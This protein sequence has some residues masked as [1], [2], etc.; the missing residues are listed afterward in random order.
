LLHGVNLSKLRTAAQWRRA[1][2]SAIK[3]EFVLTLTKN[4]V[5]LLMVLA[6]GQVFNG[7][8]ASMAIGYFIRNYIPEMRSGAWGGFS[9]AKRCWA[10][11]WAWV[12][13]SVS[14]M[15]LKTLRARAV[16]RRR[17]PASV[18]ARR[19]LLPYVALS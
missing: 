3:F 16:W 19:R 17:N 18:A 9:A 12:R 1:G 14:T 10:D 5:P 4:I 7:L 11:W 13:R 6:T 15:L 8:M 2:A